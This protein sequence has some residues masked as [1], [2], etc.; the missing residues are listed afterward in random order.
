[1]PFNNGTTVYLKSE[2][3]KVQCY[4]TEKGGFQIYDDI[5]AKIKRLDTSTLSNN[6]QKT[7]NRNKL[8]NDS[9][10][11]TSNHLNDRKLTGDTR[12]L[13]KPNQTRT[14]D[15][16]SHWNV[17]ILGMDSMS[18]ARAY[19]DLPNTVSYLHKQGWMDFKGYNKVSKF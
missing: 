1:M 8:S 13:S 10:D 18:R 4:P 14:Q 2:I 9:Q 3:I 12:E 6:T 5:Y 16:E 19:H 7:D 11:I 17:F 15:N